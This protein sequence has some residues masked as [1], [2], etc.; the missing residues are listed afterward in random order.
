MG[1]AQSTLTRPQIS[2]MPRPAAP[3]AHDTWV[4]R[5]LLRLTLGT[6]DLLPLVYHATTIGTRFFGSDDIIQ[7]RN[8]FETTCSHAARHLHLDY[9]HFAKRFPHLDDRRYPNLSYLVDP[10]SILR[11]N[12]FENLQHL[13]S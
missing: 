8:H 10:F 9:L 4:L 11:Q 7:T 6:S 1:Q 13:T 5:R 12:L 3:L 2:T